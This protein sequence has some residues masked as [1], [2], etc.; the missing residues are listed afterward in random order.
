MVSWVATGWGY[1]LS[2]T[3]PM[4]IAPFTASIVT[5]VIGGILGL[6]SQMNIYLDGGW[7]E[8][9]VSLVCFTRWSL[10]WAFKSYVLAFPPDVDKLTTENKFEYQIDLE[11]YNMNSWTLGNNPDNDYIW[12]SFLAMLGQGLVLRFIAYLGLCYTNRAKQV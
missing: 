5:F 3:L 4:S 11:N 2:C 12:A 10:L 8:A 6:P 9:L 1:A 7:V